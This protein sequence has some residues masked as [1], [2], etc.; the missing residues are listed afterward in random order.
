MKRCQTLLI[1]VLAMFSARAESS[2]TRPL[3]PSAS[4]AMNS[5]AASGLDFSAQTALNAGRLRSPWTSQV[6]FA[7]LSG[8]VV[9]EMRATSVFVQ[10]QAT[11]AGTPNGWLITLAAFGLIVLQLRRK[12]RSLP[13]RRI[14]P[15][16]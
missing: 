15:Y 7:D 3:P 8:D 6:T 14:A 1:C 4:F 13:Q 9:K 11:K 5:A 2:D 16:A 12:H 10:E